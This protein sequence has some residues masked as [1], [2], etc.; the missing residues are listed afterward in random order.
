MPADKF[1]EMPFLTNIGFVMTYRC[2]V[3]CKHCIIEAGPDRKEEMLLRHAFD[4]IKQIAS[5]R[6]GH[7]KGLSLTGGEPFFNIRQIRGM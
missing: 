7:I 6:N 5:F 3:A 4:W 1:V 2:Q